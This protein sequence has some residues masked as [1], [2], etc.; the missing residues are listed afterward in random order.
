MLSA[1][2]SRD[3]KCKRAWFLL[4][5]SLLVFKTVFGASLALEV[6]LRRGDVAGGHVELFRLGF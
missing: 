3:G 1:C 4:F 5:R 2:V 6:V